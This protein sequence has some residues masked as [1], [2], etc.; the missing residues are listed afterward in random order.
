MFPSRKATKVSWDPVGIQFRQIAAAA[1]LAS[2]AALAV[3]RDPCRDAYQAMAY[4]G[5]VA[6]QESRPLTVAERRWLLAR[7]FENIHG[8]SVTDWE[9]NHPRPDIRARLRFA[10][11]PRGVLGGDP[12]YFS[13]IRSFDRRF[14][15]D[16]RGWLAAGGQELTFPVWVAALKR[17]HSLA[18]GAVSGTPHQGPGGFYRTDLFD[19][20]VLRSE[21]PE[22]DTV[23]QGWGEG[24][25]HVSAWLRANHHPVP[26]V[27]RG[28][29]IDVRG[30]PQYLARTGTRLKKR[31]FEPG[32]DLEAVHYPADSDSAIFV[33]L[34][35]DR[36]VEVR[37]GI[38][39]YARLKAE[40]IPEEQLVRVRS[41]VM[42]SICDYFHTANAGLFF[43]RV[44]NSTRM[45]EVNHL[46]N[47]IDIGSVPHGRLDG[48]ALRMDYNAFREYFRQY[49][50]L[51][52]L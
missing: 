23:L 36:F 42:D 45:T 25:Q 7:E 34:A 38:R 2:S 35:Y 14:Q 43:P 6:G 50:L 22:H 48:V 30:L 12:A 37:D 27:A 39:L 46:L 11:D 49:L 1:L 4:L 16:L 24:W 17:G 52:G 29:Q 8:P 3:S 5:A 26:D 10:A 13:N 20:G 51:Y 33:R 18:S 47:Q 15:A 9:Q 41:E 19:P 21:A 28:Y 31:T 32:M 44:N 40:R